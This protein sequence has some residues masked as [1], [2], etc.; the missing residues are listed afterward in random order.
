MTTSKLKKIHV[1][2]RVLS[3]RNGKLSQGVSGSVGKYF[4]VDVSANIVTQLV[5]QGCRFIEQYSVPNESG[6]Y[7]DAVIVDKDADKKANAYN[8]Q[9]GE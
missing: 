7:I 6:R 3:H 8:A 4:T 5:E 2:T 9:V 1:L